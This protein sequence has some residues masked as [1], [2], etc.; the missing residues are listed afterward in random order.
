MGTGANIVSFS[1]VTVS[2]T[3]NGLTIPDRANGLIIVTQGDKIRWRGDGTIPDSDT[4]V[5]TAVASKLTF[6]SWSAPRKN[7]RSV[8]NNLRFIRDTAS[9]GDAK[10]IIHYFD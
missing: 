1:V 10:L 9:T 3:A 6:D 5:Y 4:G 2:T 8:M 7:W